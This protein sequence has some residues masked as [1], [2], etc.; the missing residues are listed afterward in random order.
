M[1]NQ[2][3]PR[4]WASYREFCEQATTKQLWVIV[5]KETNADRYAEAEIA[6]AVLNA[7][8]DKWYDYPAS[9][10]IA[11]AAEDSD[12]GEGC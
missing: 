11:D 1:S 5:S 12:A 4:H 10:A 3:S 7:R 6:Q 9:K 8:T 2:S